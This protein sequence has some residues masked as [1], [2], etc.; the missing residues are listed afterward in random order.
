MEQCQQSKLQLQGGQPLSVQSG[1]EPSPL[2]ESHPLRGSASFA[3]SYEPSA[4]LLALPYEARK[5]LLHL[6]SCVDNSFGLF[7]FANSDAVLSL[8]QAQD[9]L[10][11][12]AW[13]DE[14]TSSKPSAFALTWK[15]LASLQR[16]RLLQ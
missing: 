13:G 2:E 14:Q 8:S 16:P 6:P 12:N 15:P 10:R 1:D 9:P 7:G 11:M 4:R 3:L 5:A